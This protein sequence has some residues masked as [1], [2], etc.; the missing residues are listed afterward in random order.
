[1][2]L[3]IEDYA[4]IGDT[5]T[6][7]LVGER[8][9]DRLAVPAAVR[10]AAPSSPPCSATEQHGRWLIAPAAPVTGHA[11]GAT[12]ARRSCWRRISTPTT[13]RSRS[14]DFMPPRGEAPDV[15]RI[16]EGVRGRVRDAH[17]TCGCGSTTARSCPGCAARGRCAG[18]GRRAR[19][20]VGCAHRVET[21][22]ED[23]AT[24]AEF[25]VGRGR[26]GAVRPHLA[27]VPPAGARGPI[28]A[29][30]AAPTTASTGGVAGAAARYDGR[31]RDAVSR[32]LITLKAL[33]YAPTGGIVAAPTTSLPEQLG[34]VRNWDYRFCWLRDAT[35]T[36]LALL[37]A[38]L[39]RRGAG[40]ARVAAARGRRRPGRAADHVRRGRRAPAAGVRR[41]DWLPGY[42]GSTPVRIGN[43]AVRPVPARRVRRGASTRCT[44]PRRAG[45]G[46]R[47]ARWALQLA[48]MRLPR[49]P[50]GSEPDEGIW[51]VRGADAGTSPTPR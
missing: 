7:A 21:R 26:A 42:E 40:L 10:L 29:A 37:H 1:M 44:R 47:A 35:F 11:A 20:R 8:R 3:R 25:T 36:L 46:G 50:A 17:A 45:L 2:A 24:V 41:C 28:D 31:W 13:A 4:L 15:V 38:G 18:R 51:E 5:Q 48:L 49:R 27:P 19:T 22:G 39:R 9:L 12:A 43:A 32:S 14:I 33:T 23:L 34:G 30:G 16:V 6:A